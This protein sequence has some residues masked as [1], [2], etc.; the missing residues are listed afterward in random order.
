[1]QSLALSTPVWIAAL[2]ILVNALVGA[3]HGYLDPH[4]RWDVVGV[5]TFALLMGLGGGVLRDLLVGVA[6][7]SLVT[8][9]PVCVVLV[10]VVV[11]R[12]L[13]PV[14]RRHDGLLGPL[15]ALAL[16]T[17]AMTGA[18]TAVAHG[19][20]AITAVLV[21]VVSAVGG[22]VLVAVLRGEV[23]S[24]LQPG[25][26]QALLAAAVAVLYLAVAVVDPTVAYLVGAASAVAAHLVGARRQVST[27]SLTLGLDA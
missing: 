18:A 14:V 13:A 10:G 19:M 17:F 11:A 5:T 2:A 24:L 25:R 27:R 26:P 1:M 20:P 23:P 21:G 7:Q 6:P 9:W 22:G 3:L 15:D 4:R 8:P 12:L 16:A